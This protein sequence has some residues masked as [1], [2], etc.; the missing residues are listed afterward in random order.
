[1]TLQELLAAAR[2]AATEGD[3]DK[4]E[5]LTAQAK[6]LKAVDELDP[7]EVEESPEVKAMKA[8]LE[9][10]DKKWAKL[11]AEPANNKG[12]HLIVTEDETD[13]KAAQPWESMGHFLKQVYVAATQPYKIDDRL[14]AQKAILGASE[15][16][17]S[18]GGFLVH[19]TQSDQLFM[20]EHAPSEL[21]RRVRR[22]P[23]GPNSN[24]LKINAVDETSRATGSRWGG[25]NAYWAA[26]G[27]TAAAT[28]PKF[29][30]IK[31]ELNK[32]MAFFY[33]TEELLED[34]NQLESVA[35][36]A[37]R[38]ELD[39]LVENAILRGSGAG[40]PA[41]IFNSDALVTVA[42]ESGQTANTIVFENIVKMW[43]R[44]HARSTSNLIWLI[45]QDVE[46]QLYTMSLAIGT[47]GVPVY[48][49]P[50]GLSTAGYGTLMGRPVIPVEQ[51]S[52]LGTVGD[53][54]LIDPTQYLMI[55]KGGV[56][57]ASSMHVAFL[58]DQMCFRWT[59]RVDGKPGWRSPLTPAN[60]T[61]TQ[62]PFIVLASRS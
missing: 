57:Q 13:K 6:A 47:G 37:V 27:D 31:M 48:L 12:G 19:Q 11:E 33:A 62:S 7:P 30:E 3:L 9:D 59:Y 60:G 23:V 50:G 53:I 40:Q 22:F 46:P 43:S 18:D 51:A 54:S 29:R 56:K 35:S 25:V 49:P 45:N 16:V 28:K 5:K 20:L 15:G 34:T 41:G 1:M 2:K 10:Y 8:K 21:T 44:R 61:K 39:W 38:E 58:T 52:T 26:E 17:P 24:G 42:K 4:A 14:K 36:Q 32:L 55:D